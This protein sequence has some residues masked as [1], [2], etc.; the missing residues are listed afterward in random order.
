MLP[1]FSYLQPQNKQELLIT[2]T[3]KQGEKFRLLAGGTDLLPALRSEAFDLDYLIDLSAVGLNQIKKDKNADYL[4]I[5][6]MVTFRQLIQD[7]VVNQYFPAL[8]Q[9]SRS[10]GAVQTR[11]LA[12]IGGNICS[13]VPSCD[14]APSLLVLGAEVVLSSTKADR[15]LPLEDFFQGPRRTDCQSD[16]YISELLLP[17]PKEGSTSCSIKYGRRKALTLPLVNGAVSLQVIA[18]KVA[19]CRIALGSVAPT[20]RR[21][22]Q[23]EMTLLGQDVRPEIF[24][25]AAYIAAK[26]MSPIDDLRASANYRQELCSVLVRRALENCLAKEEVR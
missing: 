2:I 5:G 24:Q 4:S 14:S 18:G 15:R 23:A 7:P 17:L 21:A 19:A 13:A 12:T 11:S 16:E 10:V 26:E 6:A 3:Q 25:E 20:P 22:L 8:A 1:S 9:S